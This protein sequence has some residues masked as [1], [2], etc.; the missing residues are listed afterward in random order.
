MQREL[1]LCTIQKFNGYKLIRNKLQHK[2]ISNFTPIDIAYEPTLDVKKPVLCYFAH[3]IFLSF[4]TGIEKMQN[5]KKTMNHTTARQCHYCRNY[6]V[7]SAEKMKKNL[8]VC[9]GRASFIYSFDNGKIIDYQDNFESLGDV[10]FSIYFDFETTT[11]SV[12]S[13]DAKMY[14]VSYCMV[15]AFHPELNIRRR[16][17][18]RSYDQSPEQLASLSH[19]E[20]L[21]YNFFSNVDFFNVFTLK[22]LKDASFLWAAQRKNTALAEMFSVELKFT[23]DPLK[24]WFNKTHKINYYE[25]KLNEK[26]E[27]L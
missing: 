9:T 14:V 11:G 24:N 3:Q 12:V 7:K 1:S 22:Q 6:F 8:S 20:V 4:H 17:I 15:V 26:V 27:F 21:G 19:F 5:G 13:F 23:V 18:Y 25:L 16:C 10:P 2:E